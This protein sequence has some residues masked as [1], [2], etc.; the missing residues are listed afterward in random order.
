MISVLSYQITPYYCPSYSHNILIFCYFSET[1]ILQITNCKDSNKIHA[2]D[3][4]GIRM[5]KLCGEAICR[6]PT[7]VFKSCLNTGKFPLE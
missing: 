4:V 5:L 2:H 7:I 6:P 3:I 1:D